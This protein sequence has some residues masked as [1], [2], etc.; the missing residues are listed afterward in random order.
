MNIE[1]KHNIPHRKRIIVKQ[2]DLNERVD[3]QEKR[4]V[5]RYEETVDIQQELETMHFLYQLNFDID[6]VEKQSSL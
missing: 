6:D 1:A 3:V 2:E 4:K 5:Y